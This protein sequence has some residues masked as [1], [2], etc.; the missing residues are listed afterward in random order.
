MQKVL[1]YTR[2]STH[3]QENSGLSL[4][5]QESKIRFYCNVN[6][7]NL[8]S[9]ISDIKSGSNLDREGISEVINVIKK[10]KSIKGLVTLNIDR[11][12]R[13]STDYD[14][15]QRLI[16]NNKLGVSL[17]L[18]EDNPAGLSTFDRVKMSEVEISIIKDRTRK[19][20]AVKKAKG[21]PMG[22]APYGYKYENKKLVKH[23]AEQAIIER[24]KNLRALGHKLYDI[25]EILHKEG[26]YSRG[27][28]GGEKFT[29]SLIHKLTKGIKKG[30]NTTHQQNKQL[31]LGF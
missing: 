30:S 8:V 17:H 9:V 6:K 10:D 18:I 20:L 29:T 26:L 1:G 7:L 24:M 15:L 31:E 13:S 3:Q 12:T 19:A 16:F 28:K 2:V 27:L 11:L 23:I 21:E 5:Y 22:R 25:Q 14:L 4:E